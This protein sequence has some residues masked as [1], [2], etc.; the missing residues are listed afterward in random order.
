MP[1]LEMSLSA[2]CEILDNL[3]EKFQYIQVK[4]T[5]EKGHLA[6]IYLNLI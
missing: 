1:L 6:E 5:H 4:T 3:E 2:Q